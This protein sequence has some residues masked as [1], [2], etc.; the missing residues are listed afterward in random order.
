MTTLIYQDAKSHKFW[1]VEQEQHELHLRWGKVGTQG[2]SRTKTYAD[3]TT[4]AQEKAKL[5]KEKQKKGYVAEAETTTAPAAPQEQKK[6]QAPSTQSDAQKAPASSRPAWLLETES[7]PFSQKIENTAFSHRLRPSHTQRVYVR[8]GEAACLEVQKNALKQSQDRR[9]K[10]FIDGSQCPSEDQDHLLLA[11]QCIDQKAPL[12]EQSPIAGAILAKVLTY[13]LYFEGRGSDLTANHQNYMDAI[14]ETYGLE[15]AIELII[16]YER[17]RIGVNYRMGQGSLCR[18]EDAP[19]EKRNYQLCEFECR[20]R[21]HLSRAEESLWQKCAQRLVEALPSIPLWRQPVIAFLLPEK[22]ELADIIL[23]QAAG[24]KK[25]SS[26]EWLKLTA[27]NPET[28]AQLDRYCSLNI[29]GYHHISGSPL[30]SML[31]EQGVSAIS[32]LD[33]YDDIACLGETLSEINHPQAMT[34]LLKFAQK[35]KNLFAEYSKAS[36]RFP[37]ATIAALAG[38]LSKNKEM[39]FWNGQ[40]ITLLDTHP[41]IVSDVKPWL[42]ASEAKVLD[43]ADQQINTVAECTDDKALPAVLVNP[44]WL[45]KKKKNPIP[46]YKLSVLPLTPVLEE[47]P[48]PHS[49]HNKDIDTAKHA[50]T[51]QFITL[52]GYY[53]Y[54][55]NSTPTALIEAFDQGDYERFKQ[56]WNSQTNYR[57]IRTYQLGILPALP[58]DKAIELWNAL[59]SEDHYGT[60]IVM[61][62]FGLEALPGFVN[63]LS[64]QPQQEIATAQKIA[65]TELAPWMARAFN[66]LKTMRDDAKDWLLKYPEHAITG[67]IPAALGNK[68]EI[69]DHARVALRMLAS[70]GHEALIHQI[71]ER[72][73]QPDILSAIKNLLDIDPLDNFPTKR[74]QL[75]DFYT[76]ARWHRPCL[77]DGKALPAKALQHLGTM[78][79]FPTSD[80]IYP[81]IA[82]VIETCTSESLAA[83]GWDLFSAWLA[84]GAPSKESWAFTALG[85]LGNDDTARQLTPMI[86]AWPGESQHQR[87]VAG[88]NVLA[89]I[90]SDIALMQLN[91]IAKKVKFKGLR[92][93]AGEKIGQIAEQRNLTVDELDDRLAPDLGLDDNGSL[94]LDF[95][96]RQ[97]TVGFDEALKPFVRDAQGSRLKDLPRPNKS[98]D[99]ELSAESVKRYKALKKDA[100]TIASQQVQR[101]ESAMCQQRR[102]THEQFRQFL[103]EHPLIGHLTRRLVWA[104]YDTEQRLTHCFRVAEDNSYS[105]A[106][107]DEFILPEG[108]AQIGIPHVLDIPEQ[109]AV[110]FG[111]LFTDY[112]LLPPFSQLDRPSYALTPAEQAS[113]KLQRWDNRCCPSGRVAG[114][115]NKGWLRGAPQDASWITWMLNPMGDWTAILKLDGGFC[116]S[117]PP[118]E[119]YDEQNILH[120]ELW[121]GNAHQY[122]GWRD[123]GKGEHT[124]SEISD[125]AASELINDVEALFS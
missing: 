48:E 115:A 100:R 41:K 113:I 27:L 57:Y 111:Q 50:N 39:P 14:V 11:Q 120:V 71:A 53:R 121:K 80:G 61:Y 23:E 83:F 106:D 77:H 66:K 37:Q 40:L 117:L 72:Y 90:G 92:E 1:S 97:F 93:R 12:P 118:D 59:S 76:P 81:G 114:L 64:R 18:E 31:R 34:L 104:T 86:R 51:A 22:T 44:P 110:A 119:F 38:L 87:A 19:I 107:D 16:H 75:P 101:L 85:V 62:Y 89:Q 52:L 55:D 5:I 49:R 36:T 9:M 21:L 35:N 68:G 82:Q 46:D 10:L 4:A 32:R 60:D 98:D 24:D 116:V 7:I 108:T 96:P 2:Q 26:M 20:L 91:G 73:E 3:D 43:S 56:E 69:Q 105:T 13:F 47:L 78:L 6:A 70:N 103:V 33:P 94:L 79:S 124:F 123:I 109:D 54:R 29:F 58:H 65:A 95:G 63:S 67:L 99:P 25:M 102:W 88:L 112:E 8:M 74:K 28:Q 17:F 42:S 125:V 122:T 84:T 45:A 15:Y 30:V